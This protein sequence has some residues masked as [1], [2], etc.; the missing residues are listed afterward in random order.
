M[1]P[2][3]LHITDIPCLNHAADTI[4]C[5]KPPIYECIVGSIEKTFLF[6]EDHKPGLGYSVLSSF[7]ER[8]ER[9]IMDRYFNV[10]PG[11]VV[12]D[13]GSAYGIYTIRALLMGADRVYA[14]EPISEFVD[15]LMINLKL[16]KLE[17][18]IVAANMALW[19]TSGYIPFDSVLMMSAS[20]ENGMYNSQVRAIA[21]DEFFVKSGYN[22]NRL[23]FLK[24]DVEGGEFHVIR[25]AANTIRKYKPKMIIEL[26]GPMKQINETVNGLV[27]ILQTYVLKDD[28]KAKIEIIKVER[29]YAIIEFVSEP[30]LVPVLPTNK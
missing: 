7:A 1:E 10:K 16:N 22:T 12:V 18:R 29:L 15:S 13:A 26:H 8:V 20:L 2:E 24:I 5:V 3:P 14:F 19:S 11:D 30:Q 4:N 28:L 9:M 21:L 25:G 27:G 23:D 6:Y 17:K